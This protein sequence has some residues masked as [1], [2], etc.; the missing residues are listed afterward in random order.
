MPRYPMPPDPPDHIA[1][2]DAIKLAR[3][4]AIVLSADEERAFLVRRMSYRITR[5]N[6]LRFKT[7][8]GRIFYKIA[9]NDQDEFKEHPIAHANR[10]QLRKFQMH[11]HK[12]FGPP[13]TFRKANLA[14]MA[15]AKPGVDLVYLLLDKF[16]THG[17]N[18]IGMVAQRTGFTAKYVRELKKKR[19]SP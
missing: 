19:T 2:L 13:R 9:G 5:S 3:Q 11:L 6:T 18:A 14:R 17:R 16:A 1:L 4:N 12:V 15:K 8:R 7:K 10:E